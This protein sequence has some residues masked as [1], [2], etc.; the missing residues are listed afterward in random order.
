MNV[1]LEKVARAALSLALCCALVP[2]API[3]YADEGEGADSVQAPAS[4]GGAD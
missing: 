3:A 2:Y 1:S 4:Q